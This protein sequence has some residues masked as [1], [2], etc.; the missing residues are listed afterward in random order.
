MY[1]PLAFQH[2]LKVSISVHISQE[3]VGITGDSLV[4]FSDLAKPGPSVPS[5]FPL[6]CPVLVKLHMLLLEAC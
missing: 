1:S 2:S 4:S 5:P 6:P 3:T